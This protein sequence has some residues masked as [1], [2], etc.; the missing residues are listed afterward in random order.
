MKDLK[1]VEIKDLK[2]ESLKT[3][4]ESLKLKNTISKLIIKNN[5]KKI[6]IFSSSFFIFY[7]VINFIKTNYIFFTSIIKAYVATTSVVIISTTV[8]VVTTTSIG[9]SLLYN[10]NNSKVESI[11]KITEENPAIVAIKPEEEK[12]NIKKYNKNYKIVFKNG[13]ILIIKSYLIKKNLLIF[14]NKSKKNIVDIS[15]IFQIKEIK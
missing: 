9:A 12:K 11:S 5:K 3:L 7:N 1:V 13:D 10:A 15:E 4:S 2:K 14:Y 6:I 8:F